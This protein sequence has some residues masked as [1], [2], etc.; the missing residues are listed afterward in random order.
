[1]PL[2][3]KTAAILVEQNFHDEE[4]SEP[5]RH[6]KDKGLEVV[7]VAPKGGT[8]TGKHGRETVR[9]TESVCDVE[10]S[11]F[12]C[13]IIPGGAA[14]ERLR[15]DDHVLSLVRSAFDLGIPIAAICHGPQVLVSAGVLSGRIITCYEG[16]RDDVQLAGAEYVDESVVVDGNLI[17][18]RK[19]DDLPDFLKALTSMLIGAADP[20]DE[21][22]S[23]KDALE[24][25]IDKEVEAYH[26]YCAV[27]EQY[28]GAAQTKFNYLCETEKGHRRA[29]EKMYKSLGHGEYE[30][31]PDRGGRMDGLKD[32][33][34]PSD[35]LELAM[36][37]EIKAYRAYRSLAHRTKNPDGKAVFERLAQ[38]E[39]EHYRLL[40][41]ELKVISG[42]LVPATD[43]AIPPGFEELW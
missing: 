12:D 29:L 7:F 25:A 22:Y 32:A 31:K 9:A 8:Y 6:L 38:D 10:A 26:F 43:E 5:A 3:G 4:V 17:T 14:P 23:A 13:I 11:Q 1:M 28:T 21:E 40:D 36:E 2:S 20:D 27:A 33:A 24:R 39:L 34:S 16:I 41:V 30:P 19:P 37:A 35:I 18:S 42:T 15:L